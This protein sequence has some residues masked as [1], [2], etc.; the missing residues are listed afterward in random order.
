MNPAGKR[1]PLGVAFFI[2]GAVWLAGTL[3]PVDIA[4]A[5]LFKILWF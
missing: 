5:A 4:N 1:L 2:S 3:A